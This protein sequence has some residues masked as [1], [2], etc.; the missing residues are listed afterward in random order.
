[1]KAA[2][3]MTTTS[4]WVVLA[5]LAAVVA[6]SPTPAQARDYPWCAVRQG[7]GQYG[8]C[9]YVSLSQ[10]RASVTISED[11]IRN[12]LAEGRRYRR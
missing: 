9:H 10:C 8:D 7:A 3:I 11:C 1:M 5:A 4:G 12:A 6:G 2:L